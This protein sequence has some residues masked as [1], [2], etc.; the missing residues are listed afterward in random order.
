M[1]QLGETVTE[2]TI[3]KWLKP[4]GDQVARD[5]PLFEVSTDKVDSE[6]PSRPGRADR[7]PGPGGRHRR[8]RRHPGRHRRRRRP[9]DGSRRHLEAGG[10]TPADRDRRVPGRAEPPAGPSDAPPAGCAR[11]RS[12]PGTVRPPSPAPAS[13]VVPR[14]RPRLPHRPRTD[15]GAASSCRRWSAGS[16]T[17]TTSIR[18]R[19]RGTGLGGRITRSDVRVGHRRRA[20]RP[21]RRGRPV[22]ASPTPVAPSG[23]RPPAPAAPAAPA[24]PLHRPV[25]HRPHLSHRHPAQRPHP[26]SGPGAP[27]PAPRR[28][29]ARDE[30]VPFT[31]I[32]RRTAEHM[33]RSKATSAHT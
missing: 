5:E 30:V 10:S 6:V 25:P 29:S 26:R 8:R 24:A 17:T 16:W 31:N 23:A 27:C 14:H 18:P 1:P 2:G 12:S 32:R 21:P 28:T 3:T 4:V 20:A 13:P 15:R 11:P 22:P 33:V 19:V 7:D 9:R